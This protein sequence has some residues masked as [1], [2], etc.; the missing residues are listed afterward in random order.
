MIL[1]GAERESDNRATFDDLFRRAGVRRPEALALTDPANTKAIT[2]SA[3]RHL[4]Y[5]QADRAISAVAARLRGLGLQTDAVVALQLANTV[6]SVIALLGVLRAGLIA[7]PLPLLWRRQEIAAALSRCGAKAVISCARIGSYAAAETAMQAAA[8]VFAIRHIC[9]FG[10]GLPDGV[11][12]FDECLAG[13]ELFQPSTR[14]G[15]AGA[16][17]AVI[18][19]DVTGDALVAVTRSHNE[20]ISGGLSVFLEGGSAEDTTLLSPIPFGSFGGIAVALAPW[21]LA[22]GTLALHHGF[23]PQVFAGQCRADIVVVPGSAL[24]P[25]AD[26]GLFAAAGTIVA[27]WRTPGQLAAA[28]AWA[29]KAPLI[30]VASFGETAVMPARRGADGMPAPL[31]PGVAGTVAGVATIGGYR[32]RQAELDA[33]VA[34]ADPEAVIAALPDA[35]LGLRLAGSAADDAGTAA[36]LKARGANALI[37]GAFR[38]REKAA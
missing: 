14:P 1:Q 17:L 11:V 3:A 24:T 37:A 20:L 18:T 15:N 5:A 29:G 25:L 30:D 9:G 38:P 22:G 21:L 31:A 34:G 19:F 33:A 10:V 7:A 26:A 32:F 16:H 13:G 2:G 8:E 35:Y 28:P 23:D 6:E 36:A 12:P 4:T 27:L